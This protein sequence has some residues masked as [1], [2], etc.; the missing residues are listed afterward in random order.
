M[1]RKIILTG[2]IVTT[3]AVIILLVLKLDH[4]N[5][6]VIKETSNPNN[7]TSSPFVFFTDFTPVEQI[8][9]F[10]DPRNELCDNYE[11]IQDFEKPIPVIWEAQLEGC[12]S[13]CQGAH[14]TRI[15]ETKNYKYPR[16]SGYYIG[17]NSGK[18][19]KKI[20]EKFLEDGLNLRIYGE[21]AGIDV[22]YPHSIFEGKCVPIVGIEKIEIIK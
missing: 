4:R 10:F 1:N 20:P 13:S 2:L 5:Q 14:F 21:W 12:L 22:D 9:E 7:A 6:P 8:D 17:Y 15:T 3:L 11:E 18:N 16:F 19:R